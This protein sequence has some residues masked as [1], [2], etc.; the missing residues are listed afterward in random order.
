MGGLDYLNDKINELKS[1]ENFRWPKILD[2][3]PAPIAIYDEHEVINLSSN[4]Y[5][6]FANHP[7]LKEKAKEAIDRYGVGPGAVRA[8]GGNMQIYEALEEKLAEFKKVEKVLLFPSGFTAH[9]GTV[10]AI[11]DPEDIIVSDNLNQTSVIGGYCLSDVEQ[12]IFEHADLRHAEETL[13]TARQKNPGRIL[14]ITDGVF[15]LTGDIAKL[16]ELIRLARKFDAI[17]MVDDAH[18]SGVLGRNGRG[19]VDHY[20]LHGDVDIQV[21]TFSKAFAAI[22]GYVGGPKELIDY[23]MHHAR[24]I[25]FSTP[26]PPSAAATILAGLEL[27]QGDNSFLEKLWENGR[28]FREGLKQLGFDIGNS[29]TPIIPIMVGNGRKTM[30]FSDR[31]FEEGV[32]AA[33]MVYPLVPKE[34]PR[35]RAIVTAGHKKEDLNKALDSFELVGKELAII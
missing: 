12:M 34:E 16:P 8:I 7:R 19:T 1:Q 11:P 18:G 2:G 24:E 15:S 27:I 9:A 3:E 25:L 29:Q 13:R 22:G 14:L 32:F 17:V 26:L 35:V 20:N 31:L 30:K 23:L 28:Y 10:A 6:G 33:G 5:L 4:N 21:G